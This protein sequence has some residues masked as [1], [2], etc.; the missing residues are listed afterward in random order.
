MNDVLTRIVELLDEQT[1]LVVLGDHGMDGSGDHDGDDELE[2][3]A[4]VWIYSK[5]PPI[6]SNFTF[7]IPSAIASPPNPLQQPRSRHSRNFLARFH[8]RSLQ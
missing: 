2:T 3:A 7:F 5:G 1:L 4:A 6:S 8:G